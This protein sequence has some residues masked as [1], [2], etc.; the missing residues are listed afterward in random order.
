MAHPSGRNR[1]KDGNAVA[2]GRTAAKA[3]TGERRIG[4]DKN[5]EPGQ[6][7]PGPAAVDQKARDWLAG[8]RTGASRFRRNQDADARKNPLPP[9]A[10]GISASTRAQTLPLPA[11]QLKGRRERKAARATAIAEMER[12]PIE[13]RPSGWL[14][15]H[16]CRSKAVEQESAHYSHLAFTNV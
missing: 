12:S 13:A 1:M 2:P 4:A 3:T 15:S 16:P 11:V 14:L 7:D 6:I 5:A 9:G 8:S 10:S